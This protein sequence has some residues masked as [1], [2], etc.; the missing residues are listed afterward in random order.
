MSCLAGAWKALTHQS[1]KL[2]PAF[3]TPDTPPK[4]SGLVTADSEGGAD[5]SGASLR[6]AIGN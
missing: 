1:T 6:L 2:Y 3:F 4:G 5:R